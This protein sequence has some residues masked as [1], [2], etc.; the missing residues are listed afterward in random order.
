MLQDLFEII[1]LVP[2]KPTLDE[3]LLLFVS[4]WHQRHSNK[5]NTLSK[6]TGY[7]GG[8]HQLKPGILFRERDQ[9]TYNPRGV[10]KCLVNTI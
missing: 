6:L 2:P 10:G 3:L 7:P 1:R 9:R 5:W 4:K 8:C